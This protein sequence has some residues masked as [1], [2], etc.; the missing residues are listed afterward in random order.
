[1]G[2]VVG[3]TPWNGAHVLAWRTVLTPLAFGNTLVLKPSEFAPVSAGL[4]VAEVLEEAGLPAGVLNVLTNSPH[5]I[6]LLAD[7]VFDNDSV[8]LIMF[9]GSAPTA[10]SIAERAGR[11]LKRTVLELGGYNP[12][13]ILDDVDIQAAVGSA[14]FSSFFHQGQICMNAR[15]I[16]VE[17]SI[18]A[19]FRDKL[20][21]R[22]QQLRVGDPSDPKTLVGPLIHDQAA[23]TVLRQIAAAVSAGG[24]VL[25][26]GTSNRRLVQ[27]TILEGVGS[28]ASAHREEIFGPVV[29]LQEVADAEEA[30]EVANATPYGLTASVLS[31]KQDRGLAVAQRIDAG[32]VQVNDGT[33]GGE[34]SLPNGGMKHS[35]WGYTGPV[36]MHDFTEIRQTTFQAQV[37]PTPL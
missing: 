29:L 13:I 20:V 33:M 12:M 2:V 26:G 22:T 34:P 8:R 9:T 6:G 27:P 17:A 18:A 31:G 1:L 3:F 23:Q 30:I 15:K 16:I 24:K 14:I 11:A 5:Q 36:G 19:E 21:E 35:G 7:R 32:M 37:A 4:L 28:G 25:T 10:R